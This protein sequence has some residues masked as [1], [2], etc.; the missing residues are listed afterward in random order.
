M[1]KSYT[2]IY[3]MKDGSTK[4]LDRPAN[5]FS[6]FS[7]FCK[8]AVEHPYFEDAI[9]INCYINFETGTK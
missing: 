2:V 8:G 1:H 6:S 3:T 7:S 9:A 4:S 5:N